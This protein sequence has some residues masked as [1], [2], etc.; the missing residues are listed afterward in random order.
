[1]EI[2]IKAREKTSLY[3]VQ[4]GKKKKILMIQSVCNYSEPQKFPYMASDARK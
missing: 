1:M 2:L 4:T 3:I